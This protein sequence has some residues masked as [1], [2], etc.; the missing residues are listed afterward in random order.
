MTALSV[1][2]MSVIA[3]VTYGEDQ[4]ALDFLESLSPADAVRTAF[5]LAMVASGLLAS[6][7]G[8]DDVGPD[9]LIAHLMDAA[10]T[11]P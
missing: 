11:P 1:D 2:V 4:A 3:R 9:V 8:A 6:L 5:G 10:S 7:S